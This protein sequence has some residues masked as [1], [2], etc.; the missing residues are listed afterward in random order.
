MPCSD[1]HIFPNNGGEDKRPKNSAQNNTD[2][3]VSQ[4]VCLLIMTSTSCKFGLNESL[5]RH[6]KLKK[7][8]QLG[9]QT[10]AAVTTSFIYMKNV[11][12]SRML[13]PQVV[14]FYV[15][16]EDRQWMIMLFFF[17]IKR[18]GGEWREGLR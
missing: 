5:I 2:K 10:P 3:Q 18:C 1:L 12:L 9:T 17:K 6:F 14:R 16:T 11:D 15:I 8:S 4:Q 13:W 7:P